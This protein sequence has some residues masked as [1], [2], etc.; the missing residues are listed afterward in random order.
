[1]PIGDF[2]HCCTDCQI[3]W[4]CETKWYRGER[5]EENIC[6]SICNYYKECKKIWKEKNKPSKKKK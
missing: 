6:C 5:H 2:G 3:Y 1:M 4:S